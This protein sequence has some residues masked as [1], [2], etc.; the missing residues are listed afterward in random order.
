MSMS[1]ISEEIKRKKE[2]TQERKAEYRFEEYVLIICLNKEMK[3]RPRI[4]KHYKAHQTYL[5]KKKR[6]IP[7]NLTASGLAPHLLELLQKHKDRAETQANAA[8]KKD[9][10]NDVSNAA[11]Q[12]QQGKVL[13]AST[14]QKFKVKKIDLMASIRGFSKKEL[15]D[16]KKR[17]LKDRKKEVTAL[18][19]IREFN[20]NKMKKSTERILKPK[21]KRKRNLFDDIKQGKKLKKVIIK[22]VKRKPQRGPN[23][24]DDIR[25][26]RTLKKVFRKEV[27]RKDHLRRLRED[28]GYYAAHFKYR[29]E[30]YKK[31]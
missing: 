17:K 25:K 6:Q 28:K 21:P 5:R 19:Q 27:S 11:V 29:R 4:A 22:E 14:D 23:L 2:H 31:K 8:Q 1:K 9:P 26:G 18:S 10:Q 12:A 24:M 30:K 15:G 7:K 16:V 13:K 3:Y 20:K